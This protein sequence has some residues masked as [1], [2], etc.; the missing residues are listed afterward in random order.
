MKITP[1]HKAGDNSEPSNFRPISILP[2]LGKVLEKLVHQQL[3]NY[4][5]SHDLLSSQQSGFCK[6]FSTGTCLV[7]FLDE[8]FSGIDI[9]V[10][11]GVLFIDLCKAV[12]FLTNYIHMVSNLMPLVGLSHILPIGNKLPRSIIIYHLLE[13]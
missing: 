13:S 5:D 9:G 10:P 3:Y 12:Y 7:N 2:C 8:I 6:G 1:L 4:L 11:S